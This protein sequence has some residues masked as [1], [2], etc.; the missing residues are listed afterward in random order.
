MAPKADLHHGQGGTPLYSLGLEVR[1]R[2]YSS[3]PLHVITQ[4]FE[5]LLRHKF[6]RPSS[7][8]SYLNRI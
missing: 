3:L 5:N 8:I 6:A 2:F 4:K 7:T 1:A